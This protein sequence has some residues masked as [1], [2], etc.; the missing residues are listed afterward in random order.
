MLLKRRTDMLLDALLRHGRTAGELDR[1]A[2]R[3]VPQDVL[4]VGV[5]GRSSRMAA[6]VGELQ[7]SRHRVEVV[8]GT[9]AP[10]ATPGLEAVTAAVA[11][12]GSKFDNVD[13]LLERG[14][15]TMPRPRWTLVVDHDVRLPARFLDRFVAVA[16]LY[17][18]V[19]C[20]PALTLASYYSHAVTRRR[21]L[22]VARQ[23]RFVEIGPLTA[24]RGEAWEALLPF[25]A[26]AGMG[27][28][29]D[30]HWPAVA[31]DHGWR[32]G[33]VDATPIGHED[34]APASSYS[35]TSARDEA[36]AFLSGRARV[37]PSVRRARALRT[38]RRLS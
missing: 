1:I 37:T 17:D 31:E 21:P 5:D 2:S 29:L 22:S 35:S 6:A 33:I 13:R 25:G 26:G 7:R 12:S 27:W 19:L 10:A 38:F 15:S 9:L 4:V 14:R 8:I 28:G 32:L 20:Q 34:A 11:M 36:D 16:E 30:L 3:S 23:T 24:F 18:L